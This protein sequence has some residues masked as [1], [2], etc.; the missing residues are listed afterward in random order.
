MSTFERW[1]RLTV[2]GWAAVAAFGVIVLLWVDEPVFGLVTATVAVALAAWVWLR[3]SRLALGVSF[4]VGVPVL[5]Q[6]LG[7]VVASL[8]EGELGT[9]FAQDLLGLA[10]GACIVLGSALA[11]RSERSASK[12]R[13]AVPVG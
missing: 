6:Q 12:A 9:T 10:G 4:A 3:R 11:F 7:Y 1:I 8:S 13:T 5:L 2:V